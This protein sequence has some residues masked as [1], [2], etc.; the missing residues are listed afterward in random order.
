MS[1]LHS[2]LTSLAPLQGYREG[3]ILPLKHLAEDQATQWTLV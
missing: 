2:S 3:L 1:L